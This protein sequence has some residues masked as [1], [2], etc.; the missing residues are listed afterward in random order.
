[1]TDRLNDAL[2]DAYVGRFLGHGTFKAPFWFVGR[3]EGGEDDV[4]RISQKLESWDRKG[5]PELETFESSPSSRWFHEGAPLQATWRY[6]IRA[7]LKA[8][9]I[10]GDKEALRAYQTSRL[11][12]SDGETCLLELL[13]LPAQSSASWIYGDCTSLP[14]LRSPEGP[15]SL[16]LNRR[17]ARPSRPT[18]A[19][20]D[21]SSATG[22]GT[23]GLLRSASPLHVA[24][25]EKR[26][27]RKSGRRT[28]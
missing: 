17:G 21:P 22:L 5:R 18:T 20:G 14:Y 11:G 3:E 1:M 12:R 7:S 26:D 13:P 10:A 2:V 27:S 6:L 19:E 16:P 4:T 28:V 8:M 24:K 23:A 25:R 15:I 9:G